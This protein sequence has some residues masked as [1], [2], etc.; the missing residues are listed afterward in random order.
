MDLHTCLSQKDYFGKMTE[1]SVS[2]TYSHII[3][4][5]T[6]PRTIKA[7]DGTVLN[8][9]ILEELCKFKES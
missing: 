2:V 6:T 1:T 3:A 5:F 9:I 7:D 4:D 8:N